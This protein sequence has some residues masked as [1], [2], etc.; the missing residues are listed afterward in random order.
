MNPATTVNRRCHEYAFVRDYTEPTV[1][2][3]AK[4]ITFKP[5][6]QLKVNTLAG[7]GFVMEMAELGYTVT[8][9]L[10]TKA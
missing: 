5:E 7:S 9:D 1:D 10:T 6:P 2:H 4:T 8:V 3:E